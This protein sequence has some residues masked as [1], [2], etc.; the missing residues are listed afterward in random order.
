MGLRKSG[1]LLC[2]VGQQKFSRWTPARIVRLPNASNPFRW[3]CLS[4]SY[5]YFSGR[6]LGLLT[7]ITPNLAYPPKDW[8]ITVFL[9]GGRRS[10]DCGAVLKCCSLGIQ[11]LVSV[12]VRRPEIGIAVPAVGSIQGLILHHVGREALASRGEFAA[13][14]L[15]ALRSLAPKLAE[16][17]LIAPYGAGES[18]CYRKWVGAHH[19]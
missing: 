12:I 2:K 4:R 13:M 18:I 17:M 1:R 15:V 9:A 16:T 6:F 5:T 3:R 19:W 10:N 14:S 7:W 11:K 8:M